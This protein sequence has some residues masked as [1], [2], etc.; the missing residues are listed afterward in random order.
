MI[1]TILLENGIAGAIGGLLNFALSIAVIVGM[2]KTYEKADVPGWKAIIPFYNIYTLAKEILKKD[3]WFIP[4]IL[5]F[6]PIVN[7]FTV[8]KELAEKFNKGLG[9]AI[10]LFFGI[11]W[12]VLGFGDAQYQDGQANQE[13]I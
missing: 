2:W 13:S 4:F 9:T 10:L 8:Y 3:D 11:G 6:I 7:I 12:L 1:L 5:C